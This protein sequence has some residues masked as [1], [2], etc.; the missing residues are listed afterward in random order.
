MVN[1]TINAIYQVGVSEVGEAEKVG[2][3]GKE[4][5]FTFDSTN[6]G[7]SNDSF[8]LSASGTMISQS[9]STTLTWSDISKT[10][11]ILI[12]GSYYAATFV[13]Y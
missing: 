1:L 4:V 6:L 5:Y 11:D 13:L 8:E 10:S 9:S 12:S 2:Q 3:P 7:N